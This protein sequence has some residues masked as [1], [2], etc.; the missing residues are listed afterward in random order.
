MSRHPIFSLNLLLVAALLAAPASLLFSNS[1]RADEEKKQ[2]S[3]LHK[4]MEVIDEGMKK[5]KRTLKKPDQN[6][7]SLKIVSNIIELAQACKELTPSQASKLPE[8]DRKKFIDE[9]QAS[10]TK[11]IET[12]GDMKKAV[13]AGD[14][15]KAM[16]LHK[17]LKDQ[18]EDGHDKFMESD[19]KDAAKDKSDK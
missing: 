6:E 14:N 10:M 15:K 13:E 9:Y 18:E 5:L 17:S 2:K 11:L 19:Q 16:Q 4:K 1:A 7:A 8:A 12:M 3:E